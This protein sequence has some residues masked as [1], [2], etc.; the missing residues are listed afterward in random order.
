MKR[1]LVLSPHP[2]DEAVG[3]GGAL[4][5]HKAEGAVLRVVFLTSGERGGHG[6]APADTARLREAEAWAAAQILGI[7]QVDFW[8]QPDGAL[9]ATRLLVSRLRT[10]LADWQPDVLYVTHEHEMHPDHRAA[11]RLVRRALCEEPPLPARP[12][13]RMYEVWTP[14]QRMDEIVDISPYVETK[15]AAVRAHKSQCDVLRFDEAVRGLNR[16]RGEMHSWPGGDY[17]EVF[18]RMRL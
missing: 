12:D 11:A 9:R 14:L 13:V 4:C 3:C 17:A 6:R 16:Y 1:V 18:A 8:R 10:L 2:D 5:I 15:L 7:D